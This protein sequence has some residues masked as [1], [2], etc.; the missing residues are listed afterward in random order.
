MKTS[1]RFA[2]AL[3]L[4]TPLAACGGATNEGDIGDDS[5]ASMVSAATARVGGEAVVIASSGLN[6]RSRPSTSASIITTM[7]RGADVSVLAASG[8]WFSVNYDGTVGWA[9]GQYLAAVEA[10][11]GGGSGG[12]SS[13]AVDVAMDRARSGV[14]FSYWWGGGCWNPESSNHGAC[15]GSCPDCRHTGSW[16]ADCSGYVSKVWQVPG[17]EAL[18]HCSHPYTSY[19]FRDQTYHWTRVSRSDAR[20]GDAFV[21]GGH[22]FL[23]DRGDAWGAMW[24]Y[25]A[26]GCSYGIVHNSR[27]ADSSYRVIRRRGW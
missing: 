16:G 1:A 10:P 12:G 23:Y 8:D 17:P 11:S 18:T 13:S 21:R 4:S 15:Y 26:K 25:E 22:I 5:E 19:V 9:F 7:P 14:G 24:A 20:Q 6:L 27:S 3:F 2:L